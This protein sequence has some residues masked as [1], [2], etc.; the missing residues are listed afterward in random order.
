MYTLK[1]KQKEI[2]L[3]DKHRQ[4]QDVASAFHTG[5]IQRGKDFFHNRMN[6]TVVFTAEYI[7]YGSQGIAFNQTAQGLHLQVWKIG[8][9]FH[10]NHA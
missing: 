2:S 9:L 5:T 3:R 6:F 4:S 8:F 7:R 10:E 1:H